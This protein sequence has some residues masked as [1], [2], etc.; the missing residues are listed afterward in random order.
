MLTTLTWLNQC[1]ERHTTPRS[2]LSVA[3][4]AFDGF[5]LLSG[6]Q[7]KN[8]NK[9]NTQTHCKPPREKLSI[10]KQAPDRFSS[11]DWPGCYNWRVRPAVICRHR[12]QNKNSGAQEVQAART[13][14]VSSTWQCDVIELESEAESS[15]LHEGECKQDSGPRTR[16]CLWLRKHQQGASPPVEAILSLQRV[17]EAHSL[18]SQFNRVFARR[19][20]FSC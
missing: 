6:A 17:V 11:R 2:S 3:N 4:A 14:N 16:S 5:L 13:L 9:T 18:V 19:E 15:C 1:A 8:K 12:E 20:T 7:K 10:C